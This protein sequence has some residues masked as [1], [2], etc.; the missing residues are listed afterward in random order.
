VALSFS[1]DRRWL[2]AAY[3]AA[4]GTSSGHDQGTFVVAFDL[5]TVK[6][7]VPGRPTRELEWRE[8]SA[9]RAVT[10]LPDG[11]TYAGAEDGTVLAAGPGEVAFQKVT[12]LGAGITFL[13]ASPSGTAIAATDQ[14]GL[15]AILGK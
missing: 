4:D 15:T 6:A 10:I 8:A 7:G 2:V 3:G 9:L 13:E 11:T 5:S 12:Q 14:D 1:A